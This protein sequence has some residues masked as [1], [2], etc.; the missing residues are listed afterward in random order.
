M[1][2]S[3]T[4]CSGGG[5]SMHGETPSMSSIANTGR[6]LCW[7]V[8]TTYRRPRLTVAL[9]VLL[10]ILGGTYTLLALTSRPRP[11]HSCHRTPGT[12]PAT[13]NT[14]G[15]SV[16]WKISSSSRKRAP[17]RGP[18]LCDP[19]HSGAARFAGGVPSHR[20]SSRFAEL[21]DDRNCAGRQSVKEREVALL[22]SSGELTFPRVPDVGTKFGPP[23]DQIDV[24]V[25]VQLS[26]TG[27][28]S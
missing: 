13:R 26:T 21:F 9:A 12:W 7:A 19:A 3:V 14:P 11:G 18:R 1:S 4:R 15:T 2:S 23:T 5:W 24:E 27:T 17:S 22:Q 25:V 10:A 16:S 20:L 6:L 28:T 8:R